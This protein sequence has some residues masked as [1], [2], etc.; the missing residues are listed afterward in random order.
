MLSSEV[1]HWLKLART[2]A[3]KMT[4]FIKAIDEEV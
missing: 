3:S 4:W 1:V 2:E